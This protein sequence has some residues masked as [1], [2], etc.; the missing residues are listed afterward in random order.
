MKSPLI[1]V[2]IV[3]YN[4]ADYLSACLNSLFKAKYNNL[5]IIIVDNNSND[6]TIK[7]I[8][9]FNKKI[10]PIFSDKNLGYAEGNN[11]GIKSAKGEFVFLLNPDT[12]IDSNIFTFLLEP[13]LNDLKIVVSQ[14]AV[15]LMKDNK[16]LNLTGK[17][18]HFMG[19]DWVRDY[20]EYKAPKSGEIMSFS[21]CGIMIKKDILKETKAYDPNYFMYYEDSDL[22]WR[23]R[24]FG[25]KLIFIPKAIMYHDY[26]YIPLENYQPLKRKLFFNERNRI[27]TI[28]KN[29]STRT[30]FLLLPAIVLIE[31]CILIFSIF[32]GWFNEKL[33]GYLSIINKWQIIAQNREFVQKHRLLSDKQVT[34]DF[35]GTLDAK[36][37][38]NW[39]V[40]FFINPFLSCYWNIIK[41][42]IR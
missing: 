14:P 35:M 7:L 38:D 19:F 40:K 28:F 36:I 33:K 12:L 32:D 13:F 29:Y 21:G 22:S 9:S 20:G 11:L 34:Y 4:S 8:K 25:Y 26:K 17:V 30:L 23:L 2:I 1:S 10:I 5:E 16:R 37:Y 41:S 15:Y 24:L 31:F 3:T 42:L 6:N 18:T 39:G 27:I